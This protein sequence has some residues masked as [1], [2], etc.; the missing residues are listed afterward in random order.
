M[1]GRRADGKVKGS[2]DGGTDLD[3]VVMSGEPLGHGGA[4]PSEGEDAGEVG[5]PEDVPPDLLGPA[6]AR[7]VDGQVHGEGVGPPQPGEAFPPLAQHLRTCYQ[8]PSPSRYFYPITPHI[9][10][11]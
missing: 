6:R 11:F 10:P 5:H 9:W 3:Q 4:D 1:D 7:Q 8:P 2:Q